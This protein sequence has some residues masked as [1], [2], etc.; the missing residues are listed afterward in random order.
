MCSVYTWAVLRKTQ[1]QNF[2][3]KNIII[4]KEITKLCLIIFIYKKYDFDNLD[5]KIKLEYNQ[6]NSMQPPHMVNI[7]YTKKK[8]EKK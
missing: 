3:R 7:C 6:R 1:A 5:P 8:L 2:F 4:L